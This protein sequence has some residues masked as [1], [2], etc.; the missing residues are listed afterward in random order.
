MAVTAGGIGA[1]ERHVAL[2]DLGN[3]L[4]RRPHDAQIAGTSRRGR[5]AVQAARGDRDAGVGEGRI[6]R[7][8]VAGEAE[9]AE[10]ER[11]EDD[12]SGGELLERVL[13]DDPC[14]LCSIEA[15]GLLHMQ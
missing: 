4:E 6:V 7:E 12:R 3:R 14:I 2:S 1:A 15:N 10:S 5:S 8:G 9:R 13:H 11:A